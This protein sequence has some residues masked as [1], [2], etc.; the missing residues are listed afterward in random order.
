LYIL[1]AALC[2]LLQQVAQSVSQS[3]SESLCESLSIYLLQQVAQ[4]VSEKAAT[5]SVSVK[6]AK[7]RSKS[8]VPTFNENRP[9]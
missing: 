4:S 5:S 7:Q 3:V 9:I 1:N 2:H 6:A 8:P